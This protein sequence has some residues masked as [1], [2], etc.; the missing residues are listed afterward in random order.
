MVCG[1]NCIIVKGMKR[2]S[3]GSSSGWAERPS[4]SFPLPQSRIKLPGKNNTIKREHNDLCSEPVTGQLF[5]TLLNWS[6]CWDLK[7]LAIFSYPQKQSTQQTFSFKRLLTP[8]STES[9]RSYEKFNQLVMVGV[10]LIPFPTNF[11]PQDLLSAPHIQW[12]T[13]ACPH[14]PGSRYRDGLKSPEVSPIP[15]GGEKRGK[16]EEWTVAGIASSLKE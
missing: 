13:V 16:S 11:S 12:E 15:L 7:G 3:Q 2:T 8:Q 10:I 14:K 4:N 6:I 9:T 5:P 1:R